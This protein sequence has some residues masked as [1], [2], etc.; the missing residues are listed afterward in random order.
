V[1]TDAPARVDQAIVRDRGLRA[2]RA[3][4]ETRTSRNV[5]HAAIQAYSHRPARAASSVLSVTVGARFSGQASCVDT[6]QSKQPDMLVWE[7]IA[8]RPANRGIDFPHVAT[9]VRAFPAS[10]GVGARLQA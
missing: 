1:M 8:S 7:A 2:K 5:R 9:S 4:S 10:C 6:A 3:L